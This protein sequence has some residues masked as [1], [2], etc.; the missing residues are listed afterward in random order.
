V[1]L[2][3]WS[4][5][6]LDQRPKTVDAKRLKAKRLREKTQIDLRQNDT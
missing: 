5:W 3:G 2:I 1:S 4:M 6:H